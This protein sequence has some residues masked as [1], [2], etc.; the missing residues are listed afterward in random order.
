MQTFAP[1]I[2][3]D[4]QYQGPTGVLA[5]RVLSSHYGLIPSLAYTF[6]Q[7]LRQPEL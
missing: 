6:R 4:Q 1:Q 3:K 7:G 5:L 2:F